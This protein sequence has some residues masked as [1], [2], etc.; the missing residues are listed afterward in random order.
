MGKKR[1]K[2]VPPGI[3]KTSTNAVPH[4]G[5]SAKQAA[6]RYVIDEL[7]NQGIDATGKVNAKGK[8]KVNSFIH[9]SSQYAAE[10]KAKRDGGGRTPVLD[11]PHG[12]ND[13]HHYHVNGRE[14]V[15]HEVGDRIVY[16]NRHCTFDK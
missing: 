1:K 6:I 15:E 2:K 9:F 7:D 16:D 5:E 8:C 4:A 3:V 12:M 14:F 11:E 10:A 13:K